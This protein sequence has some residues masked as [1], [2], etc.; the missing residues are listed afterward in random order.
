MPF[1]AWIDEIGAKKPLLILFGITI[2]GMAGVVAIR[3][4]DALTAR[5]ADR[6]SGNSFMVRSRTMAHS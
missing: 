4:G 5:R 2:A 1:G 6:H 3:V